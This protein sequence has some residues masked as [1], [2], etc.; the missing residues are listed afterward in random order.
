[1]KNHIVSHALQRTP[2]MIAVPP[3]QPEYQG[4][5]RPQYQPLCSKVQVQWRQRP[6]VDIEDDS[7]AVLASDG[8]PSRT[9][10]CLYRRHD[11]HK[12]LQKSH[13]FRERG[14]CLQTLELFAFSVNVPAD[15]RTAYRK[16]LVIKRTY[17]F[18]HENYPQEM[19]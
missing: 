19:F 16:V 15:R 13:R 17:L 9:V 11:E 14:P 5:C 3:N 1:M 10:R 7:N 6:N 4:P 18:F 8:P 2:K 12:T